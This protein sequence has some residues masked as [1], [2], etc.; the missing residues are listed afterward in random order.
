VEDERESGGTGKECWWYGVSHLRV[1][2]IQ[3]VKKYHVD[4]RVG[5]ESI[6]LD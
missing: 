2:S 4:G 6:D 3:S 5:C 1:V